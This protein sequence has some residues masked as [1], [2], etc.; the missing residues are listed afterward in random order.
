MKAKELLQLVQQI[1]QHI[2]EDLVIAPGKRKGM[3]KGQS[4]ITIYSVDLCGMSD[5]TDELHQIVYVTR[6]DIESACA[7]AIAVLYEK[8]GELLNPIGD[9]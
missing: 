2:F 6:D 9:S 5:A 7:S 4:T 8:Y 3:E 1:N